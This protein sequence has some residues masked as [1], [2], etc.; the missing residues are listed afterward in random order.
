M[1]PVNRNCH[2]ARVECFRSRRGLGAS[3]LLVLLCAMVWSGAP[4]NAQAIALTTVVVFADHAMPDAQW[5]ALFTAL[6]RDLANG[7]TEAQ[8]LDRNAD[9]VRGDRMGSGIVV[10]SAISI[11][12][13][14]D[15][16]LLPASRRTAYGVRLGWVWQVDGRIEPFAHVDCT[17]I[18]NVLGPAATR[19]IKAK[20][21]DVMGEAIARVI[22]HEWIHIAT[23][24][25]AHSETGI[26]R[27][28]FGVADLMGD[29]RPGFWPRS[30]Q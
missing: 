6:R 25:P 5:D 4:A 20:C 14:G 15:C 11:Y 19:I 18:A 1:A 28:Q 13:H 12:L 23:Q 2:R 29:S 26:A 30:G 8:P 17:Q 24:N 21:V 27:A 10:N 22:L 7:G 9:F 3:V 16:T